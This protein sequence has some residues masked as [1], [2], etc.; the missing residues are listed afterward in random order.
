MT[1]SSVLGYFK[2]LGHR[3]FLA[4]AHYRWRRW[5]RPWRYY[6]GR[7]YVVVQDENLNDEKVPVLFWFNPETMEDDG[8]CVPVPGYDYTDYVPQ[9][10]RFP[11]SQ[12]WHLICEA[13]R[14]R[15]QARHAESS[16]ESSV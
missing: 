1:L 3:L 9:E 12:Y 13:A 10:D 4:Y 5:R 6:G 8:I 2:Q 7:W 15:E 14:L 11:Y 16:Q